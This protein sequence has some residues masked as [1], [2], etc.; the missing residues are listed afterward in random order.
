MEQP[1]TEGG[2]ITVQPVDGGSRRLNASDG[3]DSTG[4]TYFFW[5]QTP[6][7]ISI[8]VSLPEGTKVSDIKCEINAK[9]MKLNIKGKLVID[10]SFPYKVQKHD[11][12]WSISDETMLLIHLPKPDSLKGY[13]SKLFVED[14][15]EID[16]MKLGLAPGE[17][18]KDRKEKPVKVEDPD[19]LAK[20]AKEHPELGIK[21]GLDNKDDEK[22][23]MG[24]QSA[25]SATFKGNSTFQW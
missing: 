3:K 11:C 10:G 15:E 13:W 24:K 19:M 21:L 1:K 22:A 14:L 23:S 17:T 18:E 7:E 9:T 25:N 5:T 2:I 16:I 4:Q 6:E 12:V 8:H 20:I